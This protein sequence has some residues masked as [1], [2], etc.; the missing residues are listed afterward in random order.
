MLIGQ[1]LT[2]RQIAESLVISHRTANRHVANIL[3]K[4]GLHS[5]AQIARGQ[6]STG[7]VYRAFG[8]LR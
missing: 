6:W 1:G 7:S 5:R 8:V 3:D 2:N 4:L